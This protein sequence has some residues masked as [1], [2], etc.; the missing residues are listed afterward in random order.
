MNRVV[1][2]AEQLHQSFAGVLECPQQLLPE[3]A[4]RRLFCVG[5]SEIDSRDVETIRQEL[6]QALK[7]VVSLRSCIFLAL[8]IQFSDGH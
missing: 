2:V 6:G 3:L 8:T 5:F 1:S 7:Y 4:G